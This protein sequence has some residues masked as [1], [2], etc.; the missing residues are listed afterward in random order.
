MVLG[1]ELMTKT[2]NSALIFGMQLL[3]FLKNLIYYLKYLVDFL[4]F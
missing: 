1:A 4:K 3:D 2:E